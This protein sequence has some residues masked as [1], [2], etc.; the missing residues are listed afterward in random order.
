MSNV[1]ESF[2]IAIK[3][4]CIARLVQVWAGQIADL[5]RRE[6]RFSGTKRTFLQ[7]RFMSALR[8]VNRPCH[9]AAA[10]PN[11]WALQENFHRVG[12]CAV[13]HQCIRPLIGAF[14]APGHHGYQRACELISG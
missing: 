3:L 8:G 6:F 14:G 7:S 12:G 2:E 11:V 4:G 1:L 13:L 9:L 5:G 10:N